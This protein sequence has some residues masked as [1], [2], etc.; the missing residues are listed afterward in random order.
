VNAPLFD[1]HDE[2]A[3][4]AP[5]FPIFPEPSN[6]VGPPRSPWAPI[7]R[8]TAAAAAAAAAAASWWWLPSTTRR[9]AQP[10]RAAH[11]AEPPTSS[12]AHHDQRRVSLPRQPRETHG[13][14]TAEWGRPVEHHEAER[15]AP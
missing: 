7:G 3:P 15:T 12:L 10:H 6:A 9:D 13:D 2:P 5:A 8:A 11:T 14:R 4:P 1:R